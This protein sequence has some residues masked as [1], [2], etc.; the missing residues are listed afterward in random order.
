MQISRQQVQQVL[1]AAN[2]NWELKG[3]RNLSPRVVK[4]ELD[5]GIGEPAQQLILLGHSSRDRQRN[6]DIARDEFALLELLW[7][8]GLAVPRP[9]LLS[10]TCSIPFLVTEF[11]DGKARL[12][13][14]DM[15]AFCRKLAETLIV[16][17]SL[18]LA[19]HNLSFLPSQ[20]DQIAI[21]LLEQGDDALGIRAEM[22]KVFATVAM[23]ETVLLH[24]DLWLGNLLWNGDD[25]A[26]VIDW[27]DAMLGDPLGDLGK[28][29]LEMLWG[30]G[31]EAMKLYTA[32]YMR[33]R[34]NVDY[35]YL[36]F[37]DLWG[38]LRL[39]HFATWFD[40]DAKVARMRAQYERF[41]G[42]AVHA[43]EILQK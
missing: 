31:E 32:S 15:P 5:T 27:E 39:P 7:Q 35:R 22:R 11:I 4:L 20:Q 40:D 28:S 21:H 3:I 18:D 2:A 43:L 19:A 12:F 8:A 24:G 10:A 23:N 13:A 33:R 29:R 30:L 17:H 9:M 14:E 36:P 34:S 37:W 16:I 6:P 1:S 38:A 42:D 26:A 41:I 25:L